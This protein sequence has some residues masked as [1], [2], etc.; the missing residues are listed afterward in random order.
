MYG[1][2]YCVMDSYWFLITKITQPNPKMP[3]IKEVPDAKR[4]E[5]MENN[6]ARRKFRRKNE[7]N[8]KNCEEVIDLDGNRTIGTA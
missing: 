2:I 3:L 8:W 4:Q 7:K 5:D 6:E 1:T